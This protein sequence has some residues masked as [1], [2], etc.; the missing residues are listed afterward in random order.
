MEL[1]DGR[2]YVQADRQ[3]IFG[4]DPQSWG[5]QLEDY[6]NGKI[7]RGENVQL[8]AEDGDILTLT[9]RTAGKVSD[10]HKSDGTTMSEDDYWR[11]VN[12]GAHIDELAAVSTRGNKIVQDYNSKHGAEASGGW[13]YRTAFFHDFDGKYYKV[14]VSV[15]MGS[16]G[17][18]VYNIGDMEERSFPTIAGSSAKSGAQKSGKTSFEKRVPQPGNKV[19]QEFSFEDDVAALDKR[20]LQAVKDGDTETAQRMVDAA[21]KRAGYTI[22]AYHGT[23]NRQEKRTWNANRREWDTEYSKITVFKRQ[24]P[25]QAGHFFNS[26]LDNA[27]G[28]GSDLYSVY[29]MLKKPLV[30]D[31]KGQN[32]AS[33]THDGKEMDTYEW[34]DYA[35]KRRYD[36]VIF[37]NISDGVGY[38][39]LSRLTTDY[40]VFDSNRIKSADPVT[41]DDNG[42]VIPLSERFNVRKTDI[43]YSFAEDVEDLDAGY[44][45]HMAVDNTP[46]VLAPDDDK[47]SDYHALAKEEKLRRAKN[48][49]TNQ[50]KNR[51]KSSEEAIAAHR[52]AKNARKNHTASS[53]VKA[54]ASFRLTFGGSTFFIGFFWMISC[55]SA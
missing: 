4:N 37:E 3:V 21:A 36:G 33:I 48:A 14:R 24:Y 49:T 50:L 10:N 35:K 26:D 41:Y 5:E 43:R 18:A 1:Q 2:K 38:D 8:V 20:Y 42:N 6:I 40:V 29:L 46:K 34:A 52:E 11:K 28:Y 17:N 31:C 22:H 25:E 54:S 44:A 13:N 16:D 15:E 53:S 32:Y 23:T 7:R 12:A 39:D 45:R 9:S 27:G 19:K 51:I 55:F 47:I 30:I